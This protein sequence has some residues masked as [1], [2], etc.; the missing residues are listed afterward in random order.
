M[1]A[2]TAVTAMTPPSFFW[3]AYLFGWFLW[4]SVAIGCLGLL[5]VFHMAG[6]RWGRTLRPLLEAGA[7]TIPWWALLF[8]PVLMDLGR[9]YAWAHPDL[10]AASHIMEHRHVFYNPTFFTI[11]AVF[12]FAFWSWLAPSVVRWG[13]ENSTNLRQAGTLGLLGYVLTFSFAAF[14]WMMSLDPIWGSSI[15]GMIVITGAALSALSFCVIRLYQ[16]QSKSPTLDVQAL[17][18]VG[19]LMLAFTLLW[20]YA[21]LSQYLIIWYANLPEEIGWYRLRAN[22]LWGALGGILVITQFALPFFLLLARR[23][24]RNL[25]ALVKIAVWIFAVRFINVFWM[26]MPE[27]RKTGTPLHGMDFLIPAALGVI[28][29]LVYLRYERRH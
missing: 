22:G 2:P 4:F 20:T 16:L 19:N 25:S 14:D 27:F 29:V 17:H 24:K 1:M 6:G 13:R 28:W 10:V 7:Q 5:L 12:Y 11:R 21:M 8:I 23:N 9:F 18:D 26:V 3:Q 15:Y